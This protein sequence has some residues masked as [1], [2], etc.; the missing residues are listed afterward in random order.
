GTIGGPVLIPKTNFNK[1]RNKLFFWTGYEYYYQVLDTGL[2]RATVPT[3]SMLGG[4][5]SPASVAEEGNITASG[6]A[7]GQLNSSA[8]AAFG[9]TTIPAC[10]GTPN[11][12]CIDPNMLALVKLFPT[13]NAD[14]NSTGG[15]NYVQSEIFNQN[16]HQWAIR[17][18]WNISDATKVFVRYN[19]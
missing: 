18:D 17:G 4:D 19:Y 3:S 1:N 15:Y 10:T 16:N 7:P 12:K 14:P 6:K 5:F 8:L 2:L 13:P 11:G 9:G